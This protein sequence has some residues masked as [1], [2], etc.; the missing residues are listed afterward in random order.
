MGINFYKKFDKVDND[1][2]I[3]QVCHYNLVNNINNKNRNKLIE[4]I[5]KLQKDL[6]DY[7]STLKNI[8]LKGD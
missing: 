2:A 8:F 6:S 1:F 4:S 7:K 3:V 5:E